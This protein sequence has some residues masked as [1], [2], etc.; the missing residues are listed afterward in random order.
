MNFFETNNGFLAMG[1]I[2]HSLK[3]ISESLKRLADASE[4]DV[5]AP[6]YLEEITGTLGQWLDRPSHEVPENVRELVGKTYYQAITEM[7]R[8]EALI[9]PENTLSAETEGE[10]F[11]DECYRRYQLDWMI[12]HGYGVDDIFKAVSDL[13]SE[14]STPDSLADDFHETGFGGALFVC[15]EEFANAEFRDR[16]YMS[17][18]LSGSEYGL[19][20]KLMRTQEDDNA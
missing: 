17:T 13:I 4:H 15:C 7:D 8:R 20:L 5:D 12:S 19:W 9:T 10:K 18:I 1:S 3:D 11:L 2:N 14:G 6:L 16:E